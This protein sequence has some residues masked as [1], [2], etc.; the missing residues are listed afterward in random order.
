MISN[1]FRQLQP[2]YHDAAVEHQHEE[3]EK[4]QDGLFPVVHLCL[5]DF[6]LHSFA[7]SF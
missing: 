6:N 2:K 7:E 1:I 3:W 4:R 5:R